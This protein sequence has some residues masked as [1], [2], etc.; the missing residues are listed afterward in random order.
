MV[1]KVDTPLPQTTQM[2]HWFWQVYQRINQNTIDGTF[3]SQALFSLGTASAPGLA[4]IG[5]TNT[6]IYSPGADQIAAAT[7]GTQRWLVGASGNITINA[8]SSGT[9]LTVTAVSTTGKGIVLGNTLEISGANSNTAI[10]AAYGA[11]IGLA[12]NMSSSIHRLFIGDGTGWSFRISN[13][14]GSTTTDLVQFS[15][16]G[17][18]TINSP[19]AGGNTLIVNST[20]GSSGVAVDIRSGASTSDYSLQTFTGSSVTG[21]TGVG[22]SAVANTAL[23]NSFAFGTQTNHS[24]AW[25]TNNT[26]RV[27]VDGTGHMVINTPT[28]GTAATCTISALNGA[29]PLKLGTL[30]VANLPTAGTAGAGS[31]AFVTDATAT[32]FASV[33]AGG[34]ANNV[35]VY[36]DGTNWLIG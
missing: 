21:F 26:S 25:L 7:A 16:I 18:V 23:Q 6:G 22:N 34:G 2:P 20:T 24:S 28:S 8:P 29:A 35:P 14:T 15:D 5:D 13:R 10:S 12:A 3:A 31:K 11:T 30:T 9:A 32:T 17:N 1:Q 33:V 4:F 27:T 36:S 19:G